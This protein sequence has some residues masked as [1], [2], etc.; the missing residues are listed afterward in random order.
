MNL[1]QLRAFREVMLTRSVSEAA[2]SLY[3]TQP[4]ISALIA[5]LEDEIGYKLF[6][7]RGRRLHPL[8]ETHLQCLYAVSSTDPLAE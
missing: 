2:R 4:T 1:K 3:R 5:G 6:E 7:R 8:P